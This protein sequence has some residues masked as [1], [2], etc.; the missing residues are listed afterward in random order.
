MQGARALVDVLAG[1]GVRHV[2]GLPGDTG[3]AFYDALHD[4]RDA[5]EHV[6]SRDERSASFMADVYARVNGR[7]GVCEGPSGG[8]ATYILPGVAEAQGSA[9]PL[10]CL[11][12]DT[13]VDQQGRGV[14]TELDQ[15]SLF[16][17]VTKWNARVSS[18]ATIA[19]ATRRA[20][21]MATAGRPGATHLSLPTDVLE[22]ETP[23][24]SVY[25]VPE[26][27]VAPAMRTVPNQA[28]I[29]RAAAELAAATRPVIVA[30]GG[31]LTSA[32]WNELTLLAETLNI[33]VATSINGKGSIA[34][35]SEVAIGVIGG[36]GARPYANAYLANSDLVLYVGSRTDSTTT[37]HWTLPPMG[38]APSVIQVD[39]EPFEVGNNYPLVVGLIGDAQLILAALLEAIARPD[40][41]AARNQPLIANLQEERRR[42][43]S[44]VERQA[45]EQARPIKPA[46][47]VRAL[48]AAL[49]DEAIIVADPGTPTPF[50][51]AQYELRRPGR[52]T[53]IPR[54]HGGLG[55]AI[56]GV[57]GAWYAG[58][59]RR[60]VG[61][62]GDGSFGMSVGELETITR[63]GL[64]I[65]IIQCSNGTFGWIKELQH[66]YHD[67]R[68]FGVD[69]N[70]VDYAAIARGFG[71]CAAQVTDPGDVERAVQTAVDDGRPYFLDIVTES[72]VTETPP[73]AAWT[74]A[75]AKRP[76][77]VGEQN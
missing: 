67:D 53:V 14:L 60:V 17:P 47:V 8:G 71:F 28:H 4:K 15:E 52:T 16:R 5:I 12:S 69:F 56:P 59:G 40:V 63:L 25:G 58:G 68:Y 30:G 19:E 1:S 22:G 10:L 13:P 24:S 20:I 23:D 55:Y 33:P 77:S 76:V 44:N 41:V 34:E 50:L 42:Y 29:E 21:R 54:A 36:N 75:E 26:F 61:M 46:Q 3:M 70:P 45:A 9:I 31:V 51:S 73:V 27:A 62:T 74:A 48:R 11:T 6:M 49:D 65:V 38:D 66:L 18:A 32:A 39:I 37:C 72:P 35:T 7:V 57:V 64:P 43:W 2:F